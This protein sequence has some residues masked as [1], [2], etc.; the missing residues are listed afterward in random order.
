MSEFE[1]L[2]PDAA[3]AWR[4]N[5]LGRL[6]HFAFFA[7]ESQMLAGY[8]A[9]GFKD[10]RAVHLNAL[11]HIDYR[12]GTRIVVMA[13]RAGVTKGAMGQLVEDCRQL[14][15]VEL[16]TDASDKRAKI[17]RFTARGRR[18]MTVTRRAAER[19]EADFEQIV[20]AKN[21]V[22]LRADLL[23]LRTAIEAGAETSDG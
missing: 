10:V 23:A 6:L 14:G 9:A 15:L 16:E 17:V 18:L 13:E 19:I 20:G 1:G 7:F 3:H 5:N 2:G 22:R 21:Y 4:H 11:R 8:H 12:G